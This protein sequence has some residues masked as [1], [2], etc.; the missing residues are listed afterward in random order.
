MRFNIPLLPI[1]IEIQWR[2]LPRFQFS[3]RGIM[4]AVIPA[5]LFFSLVGY[6]HRLAQLNN[7]HAVQASVAATNR[8]WHMAAHQRLHALV[9]TND[10]R[11]ELLG[12][13]FLTLLVVTIVGRVLN[14]LHR[15]EQLERP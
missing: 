3:L 7:Y 8:A 1:Q 11:A 9:I 5:A 10:T 12:L 15:A 13:A 14:R 6:V 4:L 2:P